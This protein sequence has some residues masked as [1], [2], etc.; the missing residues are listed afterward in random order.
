LVDYGDIS[1]SKVDA[2][3]KVVQRQYVY[4][5]CQD[6]PGDMVVLPTG[7]IIIAGITDGWD[8][9]DLSLSGCEYEK[10]SPFLMLLTPK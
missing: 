6:Y 7:K 9:D 4:S 5:P 3:G 1:I 2:T 10:F 8:N